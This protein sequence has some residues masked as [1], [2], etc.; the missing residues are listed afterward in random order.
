MLLYRNTEMVRECI[1]FLDPNIYLWK[2][3]L[4][5]L[6]LSSTSDDDDDWYCSN[7]RLSWKKEEILHSPAG[8]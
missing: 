5:S 7:L 4:H 6:Y 2:S 1:Q 3:P 8:D